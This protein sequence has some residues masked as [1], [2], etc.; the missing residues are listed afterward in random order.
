MLKKTPACLALAAFLVSSSACMTWGTRR[1]QTTA[2][3]PKQGAK[4]LSL[5]KKTGAT[6]MFAANAPGRIVGNAIVGTAAGGAWERAEIPKP[7]PLV[8]KSVDGSV[9]EITASDGRIYP[10]GK[11]LSED[12][13]RIV[14]LV[15][16]SKPTPVSIPLSEVA[17]LEVRKFSFLKTALAAAG[18]F[19]V[20]FVTFAAVMLSDGWE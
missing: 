12:A 6:V 19:G 15:S 20:G 3:S 7:V 1:I 9:Y 8:R 18:V 4:I 16:L 2:P 17:S 5:V 13:D 14:I 11:V 10:V